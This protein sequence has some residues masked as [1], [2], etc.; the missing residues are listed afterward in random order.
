MQ[1]FG[2]DTFQATVILDLQSLLFRPLNLIRVQTRI[3]S[4][5]SVKPLGQ[6]RVD[7]KLMHLSAQW[8]RILSLYCT[9]QVSTD[10][11]PPG[12]PE[13]I[14]AGD[15]TLKIIIFFQIDSSDSDLIRFT[16]VTAECPKIHL[17]IGFEF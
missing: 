4:M 2:L 1:F 6:T 12:I 17:N 9:N 16:G 3:Y 11:R 5:E 15:C 7:P 10:R 8:L 14:Y 13:K